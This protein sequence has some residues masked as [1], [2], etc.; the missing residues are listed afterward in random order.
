[1]TRWN[2]IFIVSLLNCRDSVPGTE[3]LLPIFGTKRSSFLLFQTFRKNK[4][5]I[6]RYL[7][8]IMTFKPQY[9]FL[10]C[11]IGEA[12]YFASKITAVEVQH[13]ACI[14]FFSN[15]QYFHYIF[16][17]SREIYIRSLSITRCAHMANLSLFFIFY[18][19]L[20]YF[21]LRAVTCLDRFQRVKNLFLGTRHSGI[22]QSLNDLWP[23]R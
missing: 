23:P 19:F 1:M 8:D 9:T 6:V 12:I 21:S 14:L 4:E 5:I 20:F 22:S 11:F 7:F 16:S 17:H 13:Y 2:P 18:F 3:W 10:F 15:V